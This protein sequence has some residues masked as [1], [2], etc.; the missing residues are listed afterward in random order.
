MSRGIAPRRACELAIV[1]A[2]SDDTVVQNAVAGIV[3]V[4]LP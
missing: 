3:D 2:V 4:V 1:S